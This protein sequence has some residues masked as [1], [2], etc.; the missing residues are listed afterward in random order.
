M[1]VIEVVT[2]FLAFTLVLILTYR[3]WD[4]GIVIFIAQAS[5]IWF[6]VLQIFLLQKSS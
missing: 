4:D 6:L 3:W 2:S 5:P 1:A